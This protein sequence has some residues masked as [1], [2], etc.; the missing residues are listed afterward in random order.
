MYFALYYL[1]LSRGLIERGIINFL[2]QKGGLAGDG[3]KSRIY[4]IQAYVFLKIELTLWEDLDSGF[5]SNAN[6]QT[7][8]LG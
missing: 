1:T 8:A 7:Q 4:S 2:I 5:T 6:M 3:A